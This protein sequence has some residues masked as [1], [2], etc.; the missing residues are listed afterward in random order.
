MK[1][2]GTTERKKE[3]SMSKN[4]GKYNAL[5]L[6]ELCFLAEAK[7]ITISNVLNTCRGNI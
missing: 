4:M 2:T 5:S 7:L 3:N 6:L 1:E